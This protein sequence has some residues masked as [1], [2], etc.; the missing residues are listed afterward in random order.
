MKD[1]FVRLESTHLL[2]ECFDYFDG[3]FL[4]ASC[5][6]AGQNLGSAAG[7]KK[8]LMHPRDQ[9][10]LNTIYPEVLVVYSAVQ[11]HSLKKLIQSLV[12]YLNHVHKDGIDLT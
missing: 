3:H 1:M 9:S 8:I 6:H 4:A 5:H 12:R 2:T 11:L 10:K 7:Q